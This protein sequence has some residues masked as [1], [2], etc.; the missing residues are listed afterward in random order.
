MSIKLMS[1]IWENGPLASSDRFVLLALADYANDA[2]ECWPSVVSIQ[3]RTRMSDRGVQKIIRRLELDGW[4]TV[5]TGNGRKGCN[6]YLI[7]NPEH[8][9]PRTPFAPNLSAET[10]NLSAENPE[11][12]SPEPLLTTIEPPEEPLMVPQ[13]GKPK[14]AIPL[15]DGWVPSDRNI[16]DAQDRKFMERE[17]QDEADRFRDY[18]HAKGTTFKDWDAGWR[19]WLGNARKFATSGGMAFASGS[20]G[21]GQGGSIASIVARRRAAGEV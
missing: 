1:A 2:G 11:R 7:K 16:Q 13:R 12:R 10:P 8:R 4:L 17:I 20:S 19:T 18:H 9:S 21:R 3:R 5:L 6:R 15:P 14:R